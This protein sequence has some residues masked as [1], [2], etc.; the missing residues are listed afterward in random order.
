MNIQT[1]NNKELFKLKGSITLKG[2]H[3]WG[4][5]KEVSLKWHFAENSPSVFTRKLD[6][7]IFVVMTHYADYKGSDTH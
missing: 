1:Q 7:F 5:S 6:V 4:F 3:Y 2:I